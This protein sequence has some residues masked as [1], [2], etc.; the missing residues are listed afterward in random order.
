MAV[1]CQKGQKSAADPTPNQDH[2]K[3]TLQVGEAWKTRIMQKYI[4]LYYKNIYMYTYYKLYLLIIY[5]K[6]YTY[7]YI[8]IINYIYIKIVIYYIIYIL[9][10]RYIGQQRGRRWTAQFCKGT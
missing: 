10:Y 9:Y 8:C 2:L 3:C 7:I 6:I 1:V 5:I 4:I